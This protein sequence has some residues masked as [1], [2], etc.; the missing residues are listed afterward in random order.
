MQSRAN[1]IL[2]ILAIAL[3][4]VGWTGYKQRQTGKSR[5]TIW[6]YKIVDGITEKELNEFGAQGWELAAVAVGNGQASHYLKRPK[7][8]K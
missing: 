7:Q 5:T 3:C 8:L 4:L 2:I 6:E 1:W